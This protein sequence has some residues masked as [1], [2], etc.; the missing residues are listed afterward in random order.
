M[1]ATG[2][3]HNAPVGKK[4]EAT[5]TV[6]LLS[7]PTL[8]LR[9]TRIL[10][11][12]VR[13]ARQGTELSRGLRALVLEAEGRGRAKSSSRKEEEEEEDRVKEMEKRAEA[14][15]TE[16]H[17]S[18]CVAAPQRTHSCTSFAKLFGD[19]TL[20]TACSWILIKRALC[21]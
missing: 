7:H 18:T 17:S 15:C 3:L 13:V 12:G 11:S 19:Q 8:G 20:P 6:D 4:N 2:K 21:G 1:I 14:N 10:S 9:C 5:Q 16:Q